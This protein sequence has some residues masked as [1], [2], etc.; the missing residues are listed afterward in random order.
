MHN[1]SRMNVIEKVAQKLIDKIKNNCPNCNL[2][3][4]D[5]VRSNAGLLCENCYLPT[6]STLSHLYKCKKC[7][8]EQEQFYPRGIKYE[9]PTFCDNCNP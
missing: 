9:E 5:I 3:G 4:F 8:F 1:P 7:S 6:R 2:P